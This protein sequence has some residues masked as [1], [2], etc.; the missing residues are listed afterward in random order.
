[1]EAALR[2]L[3]P[4]ECQLIH[5]DYGKQYSLPR[6]AETLLI[7]QRHYSVKTIKR[8]K[9]E[10]LKKLAMVIVPDDISTPLKLP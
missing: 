8:A 3:T 10:A 9:Q 1:M 5:M 6:I 2:T 7:D 4:A